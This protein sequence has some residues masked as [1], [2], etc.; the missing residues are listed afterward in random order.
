[1][2]IFTLL[3]CVFELIETV[4]NRGTGLEAL[5]EGYVLAIKI[6][7]LLTAYTLMARAGG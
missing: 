7:C 4:E 1:M 3:S 2:I 5:T 6:A